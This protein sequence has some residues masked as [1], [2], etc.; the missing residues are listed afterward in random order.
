MFITALPSDSAFLSD[1]CHF[2]HRLGK[3]AGALSD[4]REGR[5]ETRSPHRKDGKLCQTGFNNSR[6]SAAHI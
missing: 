3:D 5:N 4:F 1:V 2:Q 6:M